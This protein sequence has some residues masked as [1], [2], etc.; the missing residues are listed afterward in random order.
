[1]RLLRSFKYYSTVLL[2]VNYNITTWGNNDS[3]MKQL[4]ELH[5]KAARKIYQLDSNLTDENS[6]KE[7]GW[8]SMSYMYKR[9]LLCIMHKVFYK[10]IDSEIGKMFC[11]PNGD[12]PQSQRR[13][14]Q[15]SVS[16]LYKTQNQNTFV[17]RASKIWNAMPNELTGMN[18]Y[19]LFRDKLPKFKDKINKF[20]FVY[21]SFNIHNDFIFL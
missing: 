1:M 11:V 20:S 6:L 17:R 14:H 2:S 15:V 4:D 12:T 5:A 9:R 10:N 16:K 13:D 19:K 21:N 18:S 3:F 8:M 7:A